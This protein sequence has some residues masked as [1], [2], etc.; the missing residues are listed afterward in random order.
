MYKTN[1][2]EELPQYAY[3]PKMRKAIKNRARSRATLLLI[4]FILA[5]VA[6][7]ILESQALALGIN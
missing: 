1:T 4:V 3:T 7:G 5:F 6:S 2:L